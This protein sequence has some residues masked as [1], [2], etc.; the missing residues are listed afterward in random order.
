MGSVI[1]FPNGSHPR[2][3]ERGAWGLVTEL[4]QREAPAKP[5]GR[6]GVVHVRALSTV[7][8]IE[9]IPGVGDLIRGD[10]PGIVEKVKVRRD[11]RLVVYARPVP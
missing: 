6:R 7:C 9:G 4:V 5:A 11:G 1:E 8:L 10:T 3:D 2:A